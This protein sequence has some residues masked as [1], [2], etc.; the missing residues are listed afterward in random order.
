MGKR[1]FSKVK[2]ASKRRYESGNIGKL[3]A[4]ERVSAEIAVE[5]EHSTCAISSLPV[6]DEVRLLMRLSLIWFDKSI[7]KLKRRK[8]NK[9]FR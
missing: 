8:L 5:D 4:E 1:R 6:P 9:V 7:E 3:D 2:G